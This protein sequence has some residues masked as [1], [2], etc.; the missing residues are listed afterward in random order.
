MSHLQNMKFWTIYYEWLRS[1]GMKGFIFSV[2]FI[3]VVFQLSGIELDNTLDGMEFDT[4]VNISRL[5]NAELRQLFEALEEGKAAD[6]LDLDK[7]G[8]ADFTGINVY[9]FIERMKIILS[10]LKPFIYTR[11]VFGNSIVEPVRLEMNIRASE[12]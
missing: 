5:N 8:I 1:I 7:D 10:D 12:I 9:E 6:L 4:L 11:D 3:T 2:L